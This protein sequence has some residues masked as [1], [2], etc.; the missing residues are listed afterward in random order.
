MKRPSTSVAITGV[1]YKSGEIVIAFEPEEDSDHSCDEMGCGQE[2]VFYREFLENIPSGDAVKT[3][4][5]GPSEA[6]L[7]AMDRQRAA[8]NDA[9]FYT[10]RD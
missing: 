4:P 9:I 10:P 7:K 8:G 3:L 1:Y 6:R 5:K 2:H